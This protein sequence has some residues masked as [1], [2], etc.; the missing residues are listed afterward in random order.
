MAYKYSPTPAKAP[1]QPPKE[2]TEHLC[3][4]CGRTYAVQKGFFHPSRSIIFSGNNGY[5]P[6]CCECVRALYEE[7]NALLG[8][9]KAAVDRVCSKL[10]IYYSDALYEGM[11]DDDVEPADVM[12]TYITRS[13]VGR[14]NTRTY[15]DTLSD[16]RAAQKKADAKEERKKEH[17]PQTPNGSK[18]SAQ[19]RLQGLE[20]W[21]P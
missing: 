11:I 9:K 17:R 18:I 21:T 2:K 7:Y 6:V 10:D 19:V 8:D 13:L 4:R 16:R 1:K 12:N 15:D 20:P 14:G 3:V 5:L